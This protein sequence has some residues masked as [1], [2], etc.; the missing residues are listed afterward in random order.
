LRE[1]EAKKVYEYTQ[2]IEQ[3]RFPIN[4]SE[5]DKLVRRFPYFNRVPD[6]V[7]RKI[8]DLGKLRIYQKDEIIFRQGDPSPSTYFMLRGTAAF[9][10]TKADMGS[11][12]T[13][14]KIIYD[15][16]DFGEQAWLKESEHLSQAI[17]DILNAQKVTTI[18]NEECYVFSFSKEL[19]YGI[20]EK[21][22]Q[23]DF[24]KILIFLKQL[25]LFKDQGMHILLPIANCIEKKK[26]SLG[27]FILKEGEIPNGMYM[28]VK[29]Q[30]I[31]GSKKLNIRS[32]Q[33]VG[34]ERFKEVKKPIIIR[35]DF[36]D[37]IR[38]E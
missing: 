23:E 17:V 12:P 8:L 27:E 9:Q 25:P 16:H 19:A 4:F 15:G 24:E 36:K 18:A 21:G 3:G 29:G 5:I 22:L 1:F 33:Q 7:R 26:F 6:H 2:T 38:E 31:V 11:I 28:I 37:A 10:V 14:I 34:Y 35:G 30:C 32:K 20:L 13:I